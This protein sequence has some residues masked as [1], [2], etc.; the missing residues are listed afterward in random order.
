MGPRDTKYGS[1]TN[2]DLNA[3]ST[4][5]NS[6]LVNP[7]IGL[8]PEDM[9]SLIE[10]FM[11][12]TG[13]ETLYLDLI[14]KGAFLAQDPRAFDRRRDD[15]N[16]YLELDETEILRLED[17]KIGNKWNQKWTLYALVGCCSLGAAVQGWDETA[18]NG[19]QV[20]YKRAFNLLDS[21]NDPGILGLINSAPYLCCAVLGCWLTEPLN[22]VVCIHSQT[23]VDPIF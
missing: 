16:L 18:V 13:I 10:E 15:L 11:A 23:G 5:I 19:A 21:K 3:G 4:N 17:P 14:K 2:E 20:F 1:F 12:K 9:F 8:R 7:F 22:R 6:R